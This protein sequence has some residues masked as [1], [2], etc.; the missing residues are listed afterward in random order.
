MFELL[1]WINQFFSSFLV[2]FQNIL[3]AA[4]PES[5]LFFLDSSKALHYH[6]VNSAVTQHE[7]F[8]RIYG[9][10]EQEFHTLSRQSIKKFIKLYYAQFNALFCLTNCFI[11]SASWIKVGTRPSY[12]RTVDTCVQS[13]YHCFGM[14]CKGH[15][16]KAWKSI[17]DHNSKKQARFREWVKWILL[18][19]VKQEIKMSYL[20]ELDGSEE[21]LEPC[22]PC[23]FK[24][25]CAAK[26]KQR[27]WILMLWNHH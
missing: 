25:L 24:I 14:N 7:K 6:A 20:S 3:N 1:F 23:K 21:V 15:R 16:K 19:E 5:F 17:E 2:W 27:R 26:S 10:I 11:T 8:E 12:Y 18:S 4:K 9:P 22:V 13:C